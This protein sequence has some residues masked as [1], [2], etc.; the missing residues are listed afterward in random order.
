VP[1][2]VFVLSVSLDTFSPPQPGA[3]DDRHMCSQ[4]SLHDQNVFVVVPDPDLVNA[5]FCLRSIH[6]TSAQ[7]LR[8]VNPHARSFVIGH[9]CG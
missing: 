7:V 9:T 1:V 8:R 5:I 6:S 2:R 3:E 4:G